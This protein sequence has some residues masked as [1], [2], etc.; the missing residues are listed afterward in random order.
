MYAI[1]EGEFEKNETFLNA[2]EA[3]ERKME[4]AFIYSVYFLMAAY[5]VILTIC[6]LYLSLAAEEGVKKV[7]IHAFLD[8]RDVGPKTAESYIKADARKNERIWC[9]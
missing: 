7:Y 6:L 8:G 5:I 4:Q 2:I 1:R 9:W 3:C